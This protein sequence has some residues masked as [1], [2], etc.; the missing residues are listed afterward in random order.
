[1]TKKYQ[2]NSLSESYSRNLI[3][4]NVRGNLGIN[5]AV[6][7]SAIYGVGVDRL[8]VLRRINRENKFRF[9]WYIIFGTLALVLLCLWPTSWLSVIETFVL[10]INIDFVARG[11]VCGIYFGIVDC[12]V[13]IVICTMAGLWGE[14]IR[15]CII[16]IPLNIMAIINWSKNLKAQQ[17][18]KYEQKSIEIKRLKTNG[19]F[20]CFAV[21]AVSGVVGYFFLGWLG[22]T[23]LI[24]SSITFAIGILT[25]ILSA[26]RYME[27]YI[28]S[29]LNNLI[30]LALWVSVLITIVIAG[31]S[32]ANE[33]VQMLNVVLSLVSNIYSYFLWK[34]MYRKRTVNG[35]TIL[36]KR[37]VKINKVVKLR[38]TYKNLYWDKQVDINK[39]S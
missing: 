27:S 24:I 1:M 37:P 11:R 38:R 12:L 21:F 15:M 20:I 2:E 28:F 3:R 33:P 34:D 39:N 22:T 36:N 4:G 29:I 9:W 6:R 35:G 25:K 23:S 5:S 30:S 8:E 7:L 13:Y 17:K 19:W 18:N 31:S 32:V 26:Q 14:V 10:M 16:N